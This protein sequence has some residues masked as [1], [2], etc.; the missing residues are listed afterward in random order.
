MG[1]FVDLILLWDFVLI[2]LMRLIFLAKLKIG[3]HVSI[4]MFLEILLPHEIP[5]S[6]KSQSS[7]HGN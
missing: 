4:P 6:E 7:L 5:R 1:L 2:F 3:K